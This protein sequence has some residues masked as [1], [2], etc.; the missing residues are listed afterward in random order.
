MNVGKRVLGR[1]LD[2][3]RLEGDVR[4]CVGDGN[5]NTFYTCKKLSKNKQFS[6]NDGSGLLALSLI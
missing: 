3:Q 5:Q 1:K 6:I 4:Q 2:L